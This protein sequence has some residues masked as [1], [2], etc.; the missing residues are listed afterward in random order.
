MG[1]KK[2]ST[3]YTLTPVSERHNLEVS[4]HLNTAIKR[5]EYLTCDNNI[6]TRTKYK[7]KAQ[8]IAVGNQIGW[9]VQVRKVELSRTGRKLEKP[10]KAM[11]PKSPIA[12]LRRLKKAVRK[13]I[14]TFESFSDKDPNQEIF[15]QALN[16]IKKKVS[17][18]KRR[19]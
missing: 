5:G 4:L 18:R 10:K 7:Y 1:R 6:V 9:Y 13:E 14:E 11:P 3:T 8:Y 16:K 19:E 15:I 12:R 2:G 17:P